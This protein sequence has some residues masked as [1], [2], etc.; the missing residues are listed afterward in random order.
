MNKK[1]K[2]VITGGHLAPALAVISELQ[3]RGGWEIY[4]LSRKYAMEGTKV[5]AAESK[6]IP[7]MGVE[8]ID[9]NP[10]RLQRRFTRYT[11]PSLLRV[12]LGFAQALIIILKIKPDV[13]CSFGGYVSVPVVLAGWL[14]RVPILTHEQTIVFGLASKINA[15]FAT[16]IAVSFPESLKHFPKNKVVLTGN[17]IREEIFKIKKSPQFPISIRQLAD[18][19]PIIYITGGSQGAHVINLAV[20]EI[21]PQLLE[22]YTVIHQCGDLDFEF[23]S[24]QSSTI[25]H[26][27]REHYFLASY[28]GSEEIGWVLNKASLIISRAGANTICEIAS[29]GKPAIFIPIPWSYQDEQTKNAQVLVE[30]GMAEILPQDQLTGE[31]LLGMIVQMT[32]DLDKYQKN[33]A[34]A[35]A[36]VKLDAAQKLVDEIENLTR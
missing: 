29:L 22:N 33:E 27:L 34:K 8:Y 32:T 16:K 24:H 11:I 13:I 18:Q 1:N 6:V 7:Q 5:P 15:L 10:G 14:L 25:N 26:Q 20:L 23:I 30:V 12:P 3:K 19:F 28:V 36:L 31:R 2:I 17:P 21:L 4:Y 35:K 9:F